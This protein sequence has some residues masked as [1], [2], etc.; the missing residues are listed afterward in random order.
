MH[1]LKFIKISSQRSL[2]QILGF[3]TYTVA[4]SSLV[5]GTA[6]IFLILYTWPFVD[7]KLQPEFTFLL[8]GLFAFFWLK[9]MF[10]FGFFSRVKVKAIVRSARMINRHISFESEFT[11]QENLTNSQ[12]KQ[13]FH[14]LNRMPIHVFYNCIADIAIAVVVTLIYQILILEQ[15]EVIFWIFVFGCISVIIYAGVAFIL[16]EYSTGPVRQL[17]REILNKK[18]IIYIDKTRYPLMNKQLL[19]LGLFISS[20]FI[21]NTLTYYNRDNLFAV[22]GLSLFTVLAVLL[23]FSVV[24]RMLVTSIQGAEKTV[25]DLKEGRA[26]YLFSKSLDKEFVNLALGI[27]QAVKTITDYRANLESK[28]LKR[29]SE[30]SRQNAALENALKLSSEKDAIF[31]Q[32]LIFA[33]D[34]QR[35]ILQGNLS[36][37]NG[38]NF[39]VTYIPLGKVSGDYYDIIRKRDRVYVAIADVS[40][41]GVPAALITMAVKDAFND[42]ADSHE[43]VSEIFNRANVELV[44]R[45]KTQDYLTAYLFAVGSDNHCAFVNAAH[46]KAIYY[47][48]RKSVLQL[49]DTDGLFIGAMSE[50]TGSYTEKHMRLNPGDRVFLYTDGITE[51]LN[52]Q[53]EP[54]GLERLLNLIIEHVDEDLDM[55]HSRII[56]ALFAFLGKKKIQDDI[57]MVSFELN[58]RFDEFMKLYQNGL[59]NAAINDWVEAKKHFLSASEILD[60]FP[61]LIYQLAQA[62]FELEDFAEAHRYVLLYLTRYTPGRAILKLAVDTCMQMQLI[63]EAEQF[64]SKLNSMTSTSDP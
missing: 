55:I 37:W 57:T 5:S 45:I 52:D 16:A 22:L 18:N 24:F 49:L 15:L 12:Y 36:P 30:L 33:A 29:T 9:A 13:L 31:E 7:I 1:L 8:K 21:T 51:A 17:C 39:A 58:P 64:M 43:S 27:N 10:L 4:T 11:V 54:F 3:A 6:T 60:T 34:V 23:L 50:A 14:N 35:G 47:D 41:H 25:S 63:D 61:D 48:S 42:A 32:E 28:V 59:T 19:F 38:I 20:L 53:R 40:G 62:N 46:Q 2:V 44:N 26:T 56:G